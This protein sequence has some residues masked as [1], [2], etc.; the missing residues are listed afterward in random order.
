LIPQDATP[1]MVT[2]EGLG[3]KTINGAALEGLRVRSADL[4]IEV[5][6]DARRR[7]MR[8]E[9]PEAMVVVVRE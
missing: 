3:S 5:Y 8:L 1:G 2:L 4:E 9:V 7:L 6:F